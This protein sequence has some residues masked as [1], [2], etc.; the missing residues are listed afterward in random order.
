MSRYVINVLASRDIDEIS[1]YFAGVSLAAGDRFFQGF[2][3]KCK[4]LVAFPN[5]G[6]SYADIHPC[7]R[8]L[9]LE[10]YVIFYRI[11]DDGIEILRVVNGRRDFESIFSGWS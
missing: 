2:N 7:L 11:L 6:K 4:Q 5:S 1:E 10:N 9:S 8:G 3:R